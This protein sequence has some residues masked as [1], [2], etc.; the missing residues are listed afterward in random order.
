MNGPQFYGR[1]VAGWCAVIGMAVGL[2]AM[3]MGC[4]SGQ[5][6]GAPVDPLVL[7][8]S[9][10]SAPNTATEPIANAQPRVMSYAEWRASE[11][12]TIATED[13]VWV[14]LVEAGI[15][16]ATA[17]LL[18]RASVNCESPVRQRDGVSIGARIQNT[19]DNLRSH[20]HMMINLD[21]NPW[22]EAMYLYTLPTAAEAS[23][24]VLRDGGSWSCA[25]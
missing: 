24:R 9:V 12:V 10:T 13:E 23:A 19:G 20:S 18:A 3:L 11:P 6:V 17:R 25:R 21:W 14:S 2:A 7:P 5:P 1:R 4:A 15:D 22:A 8:A 16:H